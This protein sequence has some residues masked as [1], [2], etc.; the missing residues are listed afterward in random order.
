MPVATPDR[1]D[2][3]S[4][5]AAEPQDLLAY[6]LEI[7]REVLRRYYPGTRYAVLVAA[8]G[9]GMPSLSVP[10][11]PPSAAGVVSAVPVDEGAVG[12]GSGLRLV[13]SGF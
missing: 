7:T 5:S 9:E 12:P 3:A 6:W 1:D 13:R 2:A 10:V 11:I 4:A 8:Q